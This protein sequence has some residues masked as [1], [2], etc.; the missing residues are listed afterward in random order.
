MEEHNEDLLEDGS[1]DDTEGTDEELTEHGSDRD[2][3]DSNRHLPVLE[4]ELSSDGDAWEKV[5]GIRN[6]TMK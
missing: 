3:G 2:A 6:K 5:C 1:N 4:H